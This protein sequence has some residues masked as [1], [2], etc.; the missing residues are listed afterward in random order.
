MSTALANGIGYE[1]ITPVHSLECDW[2][3]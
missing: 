3:T 1:Q 2:M